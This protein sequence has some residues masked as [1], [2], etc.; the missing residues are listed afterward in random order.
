MA[1]LIGWFVKLILMN[2]PTDRVLAATGAI[3]AFGGACGSGNMWQANQTQT[4]ITKIACDFFNAIITVIVV[5][6]IAVL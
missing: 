6:H 5:A 1:C 2:L 3:F 4:L